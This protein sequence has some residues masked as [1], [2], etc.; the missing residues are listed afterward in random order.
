MQP[1]FFKPKSSQFPCQRH[2]W[3]NNSI[4]ILHRKLHSSASTKVTFFFVLYR[5]VAWGTCELLFKVEKTSTLFFRFLLPIMHDKTY[6]S[7]SNAV[8]H[9]SMSNSVSS[10]TKAPPFVST[11]SG[12][13]NIFAVFFFYQMRANKTSIKLYV[14][15]HFLID[16]FNNTIWIKMLHNRVMAVNFNDKRIKKDLWP[17]KTIFERGKKKRKPVAVKKMVWIILTAIKFGKYK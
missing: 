1:W 14:S 6:P 12:A 2:Y 8:K 10:S 9:T 3:H 4:E 11:Q 13:Y 7:L 17:N 16:V 5:I 15:I